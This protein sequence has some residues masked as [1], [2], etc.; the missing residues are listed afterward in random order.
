MHLSA[1]TKMVARGNNDK[2]FTVM[3]T[4]QFIHMGQKGNHSKQKGPIIHSVKS[5]VNTTCI[6]EDDTLSTLIMTMK[7]LDQLLSSCANS[8]VLL[9]QLRKQLK[10]K[11]FAMGTQTLF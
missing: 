4:C 9:T 10:Q 1:I 5:Q 7:I 6:Y 2:H 11:W 3:L 8:L